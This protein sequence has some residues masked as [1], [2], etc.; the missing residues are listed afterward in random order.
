MCRKYTDSE[1]ARPIY[2][3]IRAH[4]RC[5]NRARLS[6]HRSSSTPS[7]RSHSPARS[8]AVGGRQP[9]TLCDGALGR[10]CQSGA[11]LDHMKNDEADVLRIGGHNRPVDGA[12]R[13][14]PQIGCDHDR[15]I[16]GLKTVDFIH[17]YPSSIRSR[18]T[19]FAL[20]LRGAGKKSIY[21]LQLTSW[22]TLPADISH[23]RSY[24]CCAP[25]WPRRTGR[26]ERGEKSVSTRIKVNI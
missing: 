14:G 19:A 24:P 3:I 13:L 2:G 4:R 25:R 26:S 8:T 20:S 23:D 16:V 18:R 7:C 5:W 10:R 6:P 1:R 22:V 11:F 12:I 15:A 21:A 9:K 17:H